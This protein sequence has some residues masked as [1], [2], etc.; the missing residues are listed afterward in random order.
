MVSQM[1]TFLEEPSAFWIY[2]LPLTLT[3]TLTVKDCAMVKRRKPDLIHGTASHT[4]TEGSY[5]ATVLD[6]VTLED[7]RG[8][9]T[10]ALQRAKNGDAQARHWLGQYLIGKPEG[11]APTPL[12]IVVQQLIGVDPVV[13]RLAKQA[14][15]NEIYPH[16]N[17]KDGREGQIRALLMA[18][19]PSRIKPDESLEN[20]AT[21][22]P[23]GDSA[24]D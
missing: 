24:A 22:Q 11:R 17:K 12:T 19:L 4:R 8:V 7:W 5:M 20:P 16:L 2:C 13:N 3:L 9:V 6:T 10:S 15:E 1:D 18:E 14:F 23:S 21:A